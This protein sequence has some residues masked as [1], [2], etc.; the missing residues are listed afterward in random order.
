MLC[1]SN[2]LS[3]RHFWWAPSL[4]TIGALFMA[5]ASTSSMQFNAAYAEDTSPTQDAQEAPADE[6]K[7]GSKIVRGRVVNE[8]GKPVASAEI[9]LPLRFKPRQTVHAT[10]DD[11][12][13]FELVVPD[14]WVA[15]P[16]IY[17][18]LWTLW[19]YAPGFNVGTLDAFNAIR[20]NNAQQC[21][22]R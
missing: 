13:H 17:E 14:D 5:F 9:W 10:A 4:L 19:A 22:I 12:G 3:Q 2:D 20:N 8:A 21:E 15:S 1:A 6:K 16:S 7:A 11:S 18:N